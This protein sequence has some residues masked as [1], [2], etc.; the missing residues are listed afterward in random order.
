M[1]TPS[2][3]TACDRLRQLCDSTFLLLSPSVSTVMRQQRQ[4]VHGSFSNISHREFPGSSCRMLSCC[5]RGR[6]PAEYIRARDAR[7]E[8]PPQLRATP[9]VSN[10]PETRFIGQTRYRKCRL[11]I[12]GPMLQAKCMGDFNGLG[13]APVSRCL[14]SAR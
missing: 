5:R 11:R 13:W 6:A 12:Q 3:A 4:L 8:P 10:R 2:D 14:R 1:L 7:H 9:P